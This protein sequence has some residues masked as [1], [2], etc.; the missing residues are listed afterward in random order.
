MATGKENAAGPPLFS[1]S[2]L[3]QVTNHRSSL[4]ASRIQLAGV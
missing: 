1:T 4:A 2:P 3:L